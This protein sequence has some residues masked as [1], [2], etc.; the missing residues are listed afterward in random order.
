MERGQ[1]AGQELLTVKEVAEL[2]RVSP[3]TVTRWVSS[4]R[5]PAI[6]LPSGQLRFA[7]EHIMEMLTPVVA[8]SPSAE[9]ADDVVPGQEE[10]F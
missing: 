7:R 4:G 2:A 8:S 1:L 10:L 9:S 6:V 3:S 5:I